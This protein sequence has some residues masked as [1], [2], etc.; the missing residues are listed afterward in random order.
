MVLLKFHLTIIILCLTICY[1]KTKL[2]FW[3][4]FANQVTQVIF[5]CKRYVTLSYTRFGSLSIYLKMVLLKFHLTIIILYLTM[6]YDKTKSIYVA[7]T[8]NKSHYVKL[9]HSWLSHISHENKS[10][11]ISNKNINLNIS[12]GASLS[13]ASLLFVKLQEVEKVLFN[14]TI[15]WKNM[16]TR[17]PGMAEMTAWQHL[18]SILRYRVR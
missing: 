8:I 18:C 11:I 5:T 15:L 3:M 17:E 13:T 7:R 10:L 16:V 9:C 6:R 12:L 14:A 2:I 1:N 4:L